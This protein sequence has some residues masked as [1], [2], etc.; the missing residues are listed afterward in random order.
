[1][2]TDH[3]SPETLWM[4]TVTSSPGLTVQLE[5]P[6]Q[7]LVTSVSEAGRISYQA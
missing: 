3:V 2:L 5:S 6:V 4:L 7:P 1:M